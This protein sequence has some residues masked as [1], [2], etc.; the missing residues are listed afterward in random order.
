M[1]MKFLP[2]HWISVS[3]SIVTKLALSLLL[4]NLG[5]AS[6]ATFSLYESKL[7][8]KNRA[9]VET[10]N[11]ARTLTSQ[12]QG[13][14]HSIDLALLAIAD[15]IER[16]QA[17]DTIKSSEIN[18]FL[19]KQYLRQPDLDGFRVVRA[20]GYLAEGI[21]LGSGNQISI[22]DRD[23]FRLLRDDPHAGLVISKPFIGRVSGQCV[24]VLARRINHRDGSFAGIAYASVACEHFSKM[25]SSI[26]VGG[27]GIITLFDKDFTMLARH[28]Q[29]VGTNRSI[30]M[31]VGSPQVR[32][33]VLSGNDSK[34][35]QTTSTVD[36]VER[37][38][39]FHKVQNLPLYLFVGVATK[40]YLSEW[41]NETA[42]ALVILFVLISL[43]LSALIYGKLKKQAADAKMIGEANRLIRAEREINR[44][45]VHSAPLAIYTRDRNGIITGWNHACEQM[46]GWNA[47]EVIGMRLPTIPSGSQDES[48]NLRN[49][50]FTGEEYI[51]VEVQR[52][53][54][55]GSLIDLITTMAPLR[56][57]SG[58]AEG[59]LA[60]SADITERK[61]AE[62]RVEFLAHHDA[63]TELP[64]R[65]LVQ[66][67][68]Q[69]AAAHASRANKKVALVFVD[70]D[71]F[72]SIND[73]LGHTTGD[74]LLKEVGHRL[75][76]CVRTVDTVSRQGGDEFLIVLSS[77]PDV[78]AIVPILGK[79][80]EKVQ[81]PFYFDGNELPVSMSI[82]VALYP[83]DG[84]KFDVILKKADMAMYRAKEA[85]RNT[86]RFFDDEL[87]DEASDQLAIR[88]GL[89][90]ALE[91]N[92]FMLHYQPQ[93][94]MLTGETVGAEALI[95]W[96]HPERG[97]LAPSK[98]IHVAEESGLI[99]PIG[100]WV[101][102]EAC[103]QAMVWKE[104][105][106]LN[107]SIAVNLS[108]VQF[109]RG[110]LDQ[111]VVRAL[112]ETGLPPEYLELE[113]TESLLIQDID[114]VLKT[115]QKLKSLGVKLSIDDF[116]TGYSSLSYLKR[117]N[118]DKIKIDQ[119][120]IRDVAEDPNDKAIVTAIIQMARSLNL[121]T[122]AEGV[123]NIEILQQLHRLR[124]DE[125]QGFYFAKPMSSSEF[126]Q[127]MMSRSDTIE[128]E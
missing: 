2:P 56:S 1:S 71:H 100:E 104:E 32:K 73:S 77:L 65:L 106:F 59:Y 68:F 118:V 44:A 90:R 69:Q 54:R 7:Q 95:R 45:I 117:L 34:T 29:P 114:N 33:W 124:C 103:R 62:R 87:H 120:F 83:D 19:Q 36:G 93:N 126:M 91:R 101:I 109:K 115:L 51:Q 12:I 31:Q 14:I 16:Q 88:T 110:D 89:K 20:D 40:K 121:K 23:Y 70:L 66:D 27:N 22:A 35:M 74:A 53:R 86:Y 17:A 61:N 25:F 75:A 85:G 76:G 123:E 64:N 4:L 119:T 3:G 48:E 18:S 49:R 10:K 41:K 5:V 60:I 58:E 116:G 55:D 122:I 108:A 97:L 82:G 15:E 28:P 26:D 94:D 50:I 102:Q 96:N 81:E 80:K 105:G 67:R 92:E 84:E 8:Y 125:T 111:I 47:N 79:I 46:F 99:A 6:L 78:D 52:Q 72:K 128:E 39:A 9:E 37:L 63:L 127:Y 42:K 13:S 21:G 38:V 112:R 30:G 43:S 24:L 57:A 98:F 113:L 107:V 11:L